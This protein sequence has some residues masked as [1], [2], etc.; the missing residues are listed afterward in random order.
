MKV[1]RARADAWIEKNFDRLGDESTSTFAMSTFDRG[2]AVLAP[3]R[4]ILCRR[5]R[6]NRRASASYA[7]GISGHQYGSV[8]S[9]RMTGFGWL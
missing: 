6:D 5:K 7:V 2:A 4:G 1:G 3:G 8:H 9:R